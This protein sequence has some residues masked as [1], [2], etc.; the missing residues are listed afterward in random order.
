MSEDWSQLHYLV[1]MNLFSLVN[2]KAKET[3]LI[4]VKA[5]DSQID[6]DQLTCEL[7]KII[8]FV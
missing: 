8:S 7:Q 5:K 2:I 4:K 6:M 3:V 1:D